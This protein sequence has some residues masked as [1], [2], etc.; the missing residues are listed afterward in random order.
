MRKISLAARLLPA[1]LAM[2]T[3]A[4]VLAQGASGDLRCR[5]AGGLGLIVAGQRGLTC[6]YYRPDGATEFYTGSTSQVGLD[7]GVTNAVRVAYHVAGVDP[8]MPAALDGAFGGAG[9]GVTLGAGIGANALIGG[10]TGS[11]TLIP[12]G[13]TYITGLDVSAGLSVL[14]LHYAGME[15]LRERHRGY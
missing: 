10:H 2:I 9:V 5:I 13:N 8:A 1:V 7:L 14:T 6:V 4:P 11:A 12:I 15:T 3:A